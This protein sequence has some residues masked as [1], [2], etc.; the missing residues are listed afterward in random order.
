MKRRGLC[1]Y[2]GDAYYH[3]LSSF[4]KKDTMNEQEIINKLK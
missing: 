4:Y 2:K 3:I 1:P